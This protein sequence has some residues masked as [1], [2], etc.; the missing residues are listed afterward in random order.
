VVTEIDIRYALERATDDISAPPDLLAKVRAGGR[1]RVVR[2]R[3]VLAGGLAAAVAGTALPVALLR[4]DGPIRPATRGDLA[5]DQGLLDRMRQTWVDAYG[6]SRPDVVWAGSTPAGPVALLVRRSADSSILDVFGRP[7]PERPDELCFVAEDGG[8]L[9][10]PPAVAVVPAGT[11]EPFALLTGRNRDVLVVTGTDQAQ[12]AFSEDYSFDR[13]GRVTRRFTPLPAGPDGVV[14]RQVSRQDDAVRIGLRQG[15]E[16]PVSLVEAGAPRQP[17]PGGLGLER[18]DRRLPGW[19]QAWAGV[20]E[21]ELGT[22][23][24][25]N[26]AGYFDAFGHHT[27]TGPSAWRILGAFPDGRRLAVQTVVLDGRA[28]LF[29]MTGRAGTGPQAQFLGLVEPPRSTEWMDQTTGPLTVLHARL[30]QKRGVVVAAE[31][32]VLRYRVSTGSWLPVNGDA[33]LLPD[34]ATELE[35]TPRRGRAIAISLP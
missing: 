20:T 4:G 34:A 28:R 12:V 26:R 29:W 3:A 18:L 27:W 21:Q 19:Q 11:L 25:E 5:G 16:T 7:S 15:P 13:Q 1:R 35:F 10:A 33:A 24:V 2:R 32:A 6:G 9:V 31:N 22:W 14:V 30:P 17:P 23:D 8:R